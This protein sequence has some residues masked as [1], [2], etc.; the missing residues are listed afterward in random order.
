M[1]LAVKVS[2]LRRAESAALLL[3]FLISPLLQIQSPES[4]AA[5]SPPRANGGVPPRAGAQAGAGSGFSCTRCRCTGGYPC[6]SASYVRHYSVTGA[7]SVAVA[8]PL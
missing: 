8:P 7:C 1:R 6:A 3:S 4:S 2:I 5:Q